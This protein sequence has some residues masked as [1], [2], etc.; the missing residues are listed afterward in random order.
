MP[1]LGTI[2]SQ[3]PGKI[4]VGSFES[5]A[6]ATPNGSDVVFNSIPSTYKHLQI[7]AIAK[8]TRNDASVDSMYFRFNGDTGSNYNVH[9][10]SG[11]GSSASSSSYP[12]TTVWGT[13]GLTSA[14]SQSNT[15]GVVIFDI[16]DYADTSKYKT[17]RAIGGSDKN[18][19]GD[20]GMFTG[21]WR[22]T[23]AISSIR[24][25][26]EGNYVQNTRI[27]LYGIKG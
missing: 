4:S 11:N 15:F 21:L 5:I 27:A 9:T 7:R 1:I 20:I 10:S 25:F 16:L 3:V 6:T 12:G 2:A 14:Q 23:A 18:G 19:S 8:T 13:W 17:T 22:N 26:A 24:I